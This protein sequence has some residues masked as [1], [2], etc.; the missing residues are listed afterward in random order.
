MTPQTEAIK[1]LEELDITT[2]PIIPQD[3]CRRLSIGY[4]EDTLKDL[5]GLLI[6]HPSS[7]YGIIGVN[8]LIAEEGRK[9]FTGAHELGHWCLD[10]LEQTTFYCSRE[11]IESFR[12]AIP[13]LEL[14]ANE[15]AAELLMPRFIYQ[16]LVNARDPGWEDIKEL[17]IISKTSLT[18]TARRFIELT[19]E[20]CCLIISQA[21]KISWFLKSEEFRP[22]IQYSFLSQDA[23]AYT[24]FK[25]AKP[26]DR[27]EDVKADNRLSGLGVKTYTDVLEWSLPINS[28]GQVLT[29]LYDEEGIAGWDQDEYDDDDEVEWEPPTFHKSKK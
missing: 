12:P 28:Y 7:G 11:F 14:R 19:D 6:I 4:R 8:A 2:L 16:D 26:P 29:L 3:I 25:G 13:P 15:F 17:S 22:Y 9:N 18:S 21:G 1:L 20:A 5:D 10:C 24:V 27:I 23:I